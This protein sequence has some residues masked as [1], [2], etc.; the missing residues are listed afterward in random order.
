ME[1][2]TLNHSKKVFAS[3]PYR[4]RDGARTGFVGRTHE[5]KMITAAWIGG[6]A[7]PPLCPL[8]VGEPGVGK[9]RLVYELARRSGLDL[10]IFQG[11][12]DVTAEDM[13]CTVRFSDEPGKNMDYVASPMVTAMHRGGIC[14]IDEIGKVRPRALALLA[15]VL[16]ER[17]YIDSTLLGERIQAHPKFRFVA[18]TNTGE[19]AGLPEF[20]RSRLRPLIQVGP[21]PK[22]EINEIISKQAANEPE[23][24]KL[25]ASFWDLFASIERT[26][27]P[28]D[29]VHLF[30]LAGSL[31]D[32]GVGETERRVSGN[33]SGH[34]V[35]SETADDAYPITPEH[36][37]EA[38]NQLF[39]QEEPT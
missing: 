28:R 33:G 22:E 5:M 27:T 8:L 34:H 18:A 1:T 24:E 37:G 14:F 35:L 12:E 7:L 29:A 25:L 39:R 21:P 36:L 10:Y 19:V 11:H 4:P 26:P 16:D 2:I 3:E 38:F 6:S 17:R 23:L 20:I 9:N 30:A 31:R 15:S 32:Y 13:A